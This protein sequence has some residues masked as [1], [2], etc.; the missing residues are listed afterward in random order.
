[1]V[2]SFISFYKS[3]EESGFLVEK[4]DSILFKGGYSKKD[5]QR[6]ILS[7]PY[8]TFEDRQMIYH[9]KS[10]GIIEMDSILW[11]NL[12]IEERKSICQICDNKIDDYYNR[13]VT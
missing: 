11:K 4:S 12:S 13:I 6:L 8:K 3:R 1:M 9:T 2:D 7:Y 5:I 10:L